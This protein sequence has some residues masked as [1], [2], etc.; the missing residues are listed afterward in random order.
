[1]SVFALGAVALSSVI[2]AGLVT[3]AM[4]QIMSRP[5]RYVLVAIAALLWVPLSM[6]LIWL[7]VYLT[8][9]HRY[10]V[11][12]GDVP[13]VQAPVSA[14][15]VCYQYGLATGTMLVVQFRVSEEDFLGWM[16]SRGWEPEPITVSERVTAFPDD[17]SKGVGTKR[18]VVA[19]G[20][21]FDDY[22][23]DR[24]D[25]S[26]TTVVYDRATG[27]AHLSRTRF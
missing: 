9:T 16:E 1:M 10:D 7:S 14:T 8:T 18:I 27:L 3:I 12:P 23:K 5:L 13:I 26:G 20:L 19:D 2:V 21:R 15:N 25:D 22:D 11:K 17:R 4:T 6:G 24:F